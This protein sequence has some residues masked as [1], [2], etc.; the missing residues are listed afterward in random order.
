MATIA[1]ALET[2]REAALSYPDAY[3]DHPWGDTVFKVA[4][5]IF[6][7]MTPWEGGLNVTVKLPHSFE[8]ALEY[9]FAKPAPYNLGRS[10]W[11]LCRFEH[12]EKVPVP[13]LRPW[14]DES[15]R[16]VA[17]KRLVKALPGQDE[18]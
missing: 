10:R 18:V 3:E 17:P 2:L 15:F 13:V 16:A 6:L 12:G 9:P 4:G 1:K 14:L 5:K 11:A 8:F 7:F